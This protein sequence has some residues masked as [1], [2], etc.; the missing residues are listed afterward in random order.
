[1]SDLIIVPCI[2]LH[3]YS[4]RSASTRENQGTRFEL[5]GWNKNSGRQTDDLLRKRFRLF[6]E[7]LTLSQW[8]P[9]CTCKSFFTA[10]GNLPLY[11]WVLERWHLEVRYLLKQ[12][13]VRRNLGGIVLDNPETATL[14]ASTCAPMCE[15]PEKYL[16]P[17]LDLS[18][19][20]EHLQRAAGLRTCHC[21][22]GN[23][24]K[25]HRVTLKYLAM[26][27]WCGFI[28]GCLYER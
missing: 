14:G 3:V 1:M 11:K 22:A 2:G 23:F 28:S 20:G 4:Q 24:L 12:Y 8:P 17:P 27:I 26:G 10:E 19:G 15:Q 9:L 21:L 6:H 5:I 13:D 25:S 18:E 16:I 7:H